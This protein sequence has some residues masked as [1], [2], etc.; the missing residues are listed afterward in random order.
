M[1]ELKYHEKK[2]MRKVSLYEYKTQRGKRNV[3]ENEL[4]QRY[5]VTKRQDFHSYVRL[6]GKLK[7]LGQ[8][9]EQLAAND[10]YRV[11]LTDEILTKMYD[12]GL[13]PVKRSLQQILD[14]SASAFARR[15]LAVVVVKLKMAQ[16]I[17]QAH[18]DIERGHIRVGT[19]TITDP[20]YHVTRVMEDFTTWTTRSKRR[21]TVEKYND[22]L[23]D[24]DLLQV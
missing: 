20:A 3:R 8:S 21:R 16:S 24:Y 18:E 23:D 13:I 12:M 14:L 4:M 7:Q 22:R 15:R 5:H 19:E 17:R 2:L 9:L 10:A 6:A 1:R 11:R